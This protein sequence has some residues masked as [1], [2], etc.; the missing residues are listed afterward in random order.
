MP[1]VVGARNCRT[2]GIGRVRIRAE[3]TQSLIGAGCQ[4]HQASGG[5]N[6]VCISVRASVA[7][8]APIESWRSKLMSPLEAASESHSA[9]S[10]PSACDGGADSSGVTG[11]RTH[12]IHDFPSARTWFPW[13]PWIP[14]SGAALPPPARRQ[15]INSSLNRSDS[16]RP[17]LRP[18]CMVN[19]R[20]APSELGTAT[21]R[22]CSLL[23]AWRPARR[24]RSPSK[25]LP[26]TDIY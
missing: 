13:R 17:I 21:P 19:R 7:R 11:R 26:S 2:T 8:V 10:G 20:L 24:L 5:V 16:S 6:T 18:Q 4:S 14:W 15:A 9:T 3:R 12:G 1:A 22:K 23:V 25:N